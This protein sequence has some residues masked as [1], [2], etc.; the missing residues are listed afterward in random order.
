MWLHASSCASLCGE[1]FFVCLFVCLFACSSV[2]V[3]LRMRGNECDDCINMSAYVYIYT[4]VCLRV[5]VCVRSNACASL[6]CMFVRKCVRE[7][8]YLF[9]LCSW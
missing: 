5:C 2:V 6:N 8:V 1:T 4:C 7:C 3:R 9:V